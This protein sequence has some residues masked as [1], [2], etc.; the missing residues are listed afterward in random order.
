MITLGVRKRWRLL[1][2]LLAL[3]VVAGAAWFAAARTVSPQQAAAFAAPPS[4]SLLTSRLQTR[5]VS[6]IVAANGTVTQ[7][8]MKAPIAMPPLGDGIAVVTRALPSSG[9]SLHAGA[10][11]AAISGQPIFLLEGQLPAYR[12]LTAGDTG[13]DVTQLQTG[14]ARA[15]YDAGRSGRIDDA[16][17]E[18][19]RRMWAAAGQVLPNPNG[20]AGGAGGS[21]QAGSAVAGGGASPEPATASPSPS[22]TARPIQPP[23]DPD[24]SVVLSRSS[25]VF[26]PKLPAT[27]LSSTGAVGE[28]VRDLALAVR[29]GQP[30]LSLQIDDGQPQSVAPGASVVATIAGSSYNG[31]VTAVSAHSASAAAGGTTTRLCTVRVH[32][33]SHLKPGQLAVATITVSSS[34]HPVLAAPVAAVHQDQSG[35]TSVDV[36]DARGHFRRLAVRTGVNGG[37]Y[38]QVAALGGNQL[39]DGDTVALNW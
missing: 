5:V 11:I 1:T 31:T 27:V 33:A 7:P 9:S 34:G 18:A 29:V 22:T 20:T 39:H 15:G 26:L 14:L 2:L 35:T 21:S 24:L 17:V 19:V 38:V 8:A 36:R 28:V 13:P 32:G 12:D 23:S 25:L 10:E 6:S 3:V 16:T 4:P 30:T 37:G